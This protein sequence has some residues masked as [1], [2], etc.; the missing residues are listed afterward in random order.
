VA[1]A[2]IYL[3]AVVGGYALAGNSGVL[4]GWTFAAALASSALVVWITVVNL[5]YLL[6]QMAIAV[7]DLGVRQAVVRVGQFIR[8]SLREVAGIFGVVLLLVGV[9]TIASI[10]A[11]AGLGL[12]AF[13]PLVGL[14]MVPLQVAAWLLRG[15]VFEYLALTAFGAYLTQYR[16]YLHSLAAVRLE[17]TPP[18]V[19]GEGLA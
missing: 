11:T 16:Y 3:S 14:A 7:E 2:V 5:L 10:M 17:D 15:F 4:L 1:T 8:A 6:T 19:P 9:A 12:I 13:V 18:A